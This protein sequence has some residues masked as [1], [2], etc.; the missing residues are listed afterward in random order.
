MGAS[1]FGNYA[2]NILAKELPKS[3][4]VTIEDKKPF[5]FI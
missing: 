4:N 1:N 2:A 5:S 3:S